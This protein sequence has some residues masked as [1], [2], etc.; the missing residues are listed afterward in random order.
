MVA[1]RGGAPIFPLH[2]RDHTQLL[3]R[4][5]RTLGLYTALS[6]KLAAGLFRVVPSFAEAGW[7]GTNAARRGLANDVAWTPVEGG[8]EEM[9]VTKRFGKPDSMSILFIRSEEDEVFER[10]IRNIQG[11]EVMNLEDV[12]VYHILKYK[13]CV[14]E[15]EAVEALSAMDMGLEAFEGLDLAE[16]EAL[17]ESANVPIA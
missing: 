9:N 13:W 7:E 12:Q 11:V 16:E 6:S 17:E 4:K 15:K 10:V 3:P 1:G 8:Q 2:P 14:M 5:I